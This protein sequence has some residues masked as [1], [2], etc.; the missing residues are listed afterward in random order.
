MSVRFES[1]NS[2][3]A[4]DASFLADGNIVCTMGFYVYLH[5]LPS[6]GNFAALATCY[7][8]FA[9]WSIEIDDAGHLRIYDFNSIARSSAGT[10]TL[11]INTWYYVWFRKPSTGGANAFLYVDGATSA[12]VT[13]TVACAAAAHPIVFAS[14]NGK[15]GAYGSATYADCS[16][17]NVKF[18]NGDVAASEANNEKDTF[19]VVNS[20]NSYAAWQLD[21]HTDLTDGVGSNDLTASGTLSAGATNPFG[22]AATLLF[23]AIHQHA[24]G[25]L[26]PGLRSL[27]IR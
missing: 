24:P 27:A 19:T 18:W 26:P 12:D 17:V 16:L 3:R 25:L 11:S 1:A 22:A 8:S 4:S 6:S 15:A 5:S 2:E 7:A 9:G 13:R 14:D 23:P 20:T 10:A 21:V